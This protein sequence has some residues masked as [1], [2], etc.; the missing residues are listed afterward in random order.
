MFDPHEIRRDVEYEGGGNDSWLVGSKDRRVK[1]E[2]DDGDRWFFFLSL[3]SFFF[4]PPR[5]TNEIEIYFLY[6]RVI[7]FNVTGEF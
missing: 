4:F 5:K 6:T 7:K 1:K 3:F 2:I